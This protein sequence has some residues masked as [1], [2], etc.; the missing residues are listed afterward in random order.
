MKL[1][2]RCQNCDFCDKGMK[3]IQ[4]NESVKETK[5]HIRNQHNKQKCKKYMNNLQNYNIIFLNVTIVSIDHKKEHI[6]NSH[7]I[8][9]CS[10]F[11]PAKLNMK[12]NNDLNKFKMEDD[13][14]NENW[15]NDLRN[16]YKGSPII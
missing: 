1:Y 8:T 3:S 13:F 14:K 12:N 16:F 10:K 5:Q 4:R 7:E 11:V 6:L 2:Y 9:Y 15:K